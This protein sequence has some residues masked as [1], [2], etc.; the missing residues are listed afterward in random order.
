MKP[1]E[2]VL[3]PEQEVEQ[4]K[5]VQLETRFEGKGLK[6]ETFIQ[7]VSILANLMDYEA[8]KNVTA[9]EISFES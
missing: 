9:N 1:G 7:L 4:A 8:D 2:I 3:N 6:P 5:I